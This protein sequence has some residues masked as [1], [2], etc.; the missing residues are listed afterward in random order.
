MPCAFEC[1]SRAAYDHDTETANIGVVPVGWG[2]VDPTLE[3]S[4]PE[5]SD[6]KDTSFQVASCDPILRPAM[7]AHSS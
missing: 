4:F 1:Y 2:A 3:G 6:E 7:H 5:A